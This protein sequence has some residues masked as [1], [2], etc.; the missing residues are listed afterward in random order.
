MNLTW[1]QIVDLA[2]DT[3]SA[4]NGKKLSQP[5]N[6][7]EQGQSDD[8][9]WGY[10]KGSG[11]KPYQVGVCLSTMAYKCSCPSRKLPCKHVLGLMMLGASDAA[12]LPQNTPPDWLDEWLSR[13]QS[14]AQKKAARDSAPADPKAQA[15]RAAKRQQLV[16]AGL[17][18]LDIW[19]HDLVRNGL[20]GLDAQPLQFWETQVARL[21]DAQ[22]GG[23]ASRVRRL[24]DLPSA[25]ADWPIHMLRQLGQLKLAS[26]A[27]R[28]I[29]TLH[30]PLQ[31]DLRQYIGWDLKQEDILAHGDLVKDEWFVLGQWVDDQERLRIQAT[32]LTGRG[33]CRQA[34]ILQFAPFNQ[35]FGEVIVPGVIQSAEL[36]FYPS[37]YPQRARLLRRED[38]AAPIRE[39]LPGDALI[40]DFYDRLAEA[41]SQQPWLERF[42]CVLQ[43]VV[44]VCRD[45]TWYV[46]D[47][48]GRGLRL[49]GRDHWRFL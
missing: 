21:V 45:Q 33:T 11:S 49:Y 35:S 37:H 15:K 28:H 29:D 23:L 14:T 32:W 4:D 2:P 48:N 43:S 16:N 18:Q 47:R 46:V 38:Q 17:D 24:A 27:F 42:A 5:Q 40:D 41:L 20:A 13:R 22:A 39:P 9:L 7:S 12:H 3:K 1:E 34:L 25:H 26:H 6:W 10:C 30:P 36:V 44:P 19:L 31:A 8:A